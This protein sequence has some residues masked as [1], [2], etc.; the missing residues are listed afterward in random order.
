MFK[1]PEITY[2]LTIDTIGKHLALGYE[3]FVHCL[4]KDCGH[5]SRINLVALAGKLGMDHRCSAD[6]LHPHFYCS[7]CRAAGRPDKNLQ[8]QVSPLIDP[9]SAWPREG[10]K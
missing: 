4:S 3:L 10:R 5:H 8:F 2:P 1:F 9:H 7:K 6:D